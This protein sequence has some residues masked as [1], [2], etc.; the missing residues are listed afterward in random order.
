MY[1]CKALGAGD[2]KL[3]SLLSVFS[4]QEQF[5]CVLVYIIAAA[6]AIGMLKLLH[7]R[8]LLERMK[9]LCHFAGQTILTG[10]ISVYD[11]NDRAD[12]WN[13]RIHFSVPILLGYIG[14]LCIR[15]WG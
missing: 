15:K 9:A 10:R 8:I 14:Y 3:L 7:E 11:G 1:H 4:T 6:A 12:R 2:I 13:N 5:F